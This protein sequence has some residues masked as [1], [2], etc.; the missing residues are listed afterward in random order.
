MK[1]A[2]G[3]LKQNLQRLEKSAQK[4]VETRGYTQDV[5]KI[6]MLGELI[7]E[8]LINENSRPATRTVR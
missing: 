4:I 3:R 7:K 6:K 1:E 8:Q 2:T 5:E